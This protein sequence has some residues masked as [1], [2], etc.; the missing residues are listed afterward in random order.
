M[1]AEIITIGDEILIGQ[2]ID[3][4]S[5]WIAEQFNRAGIE[6]YQVTSVHDDYLHITEALKK[7]EEKVDLVIITGGLGPTKDDI[8]KNTLCKYFGTKLVFHEPTFEKIKKRFANRNISM[9]K[10]NR[11]Q[12]LLPESCTI[13]PNNAGTA[14]G[15]W[16]EKGDTIIV[17]VPGIPFEMKYL[18]TNE[19]LPRLRGNGKLKAI[20]HKTVLT[21]GLP[22]SMLAEKLSEW[23]DSLPGYIKLAYLPN[24][25]AVR[26]RLSA[27]GDDGKMLRESVEKKIKELQQLIPENIYGYDDDRLAGVIG[28]LLVKKNASLA[29]AESCTGGYISHLIT[30][31]PGC[32]SY[33]KGSVTAYS[34]EVKENIL[35]VSPNTLEEYGAV[36]KQVATEMALGVKKA[37]DTD[38]AVATTGIAG[39]GGGTEEKP[40]GTVW[41]AVATPAKTVAE[42]YVFGGNRER[43]IIRSAQTALQLLRKLVLKE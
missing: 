27:I 31:T 11:D 22:E 3:T 40:V 37:I 26:L 38:Y 34:N 10:L 7:A 12:A 4:N 20:Y 32:S 2:I 1:K 19:I 21:Q 39:P 24:P 6:V 29:I 13:L 35:E 36:S 17:S 30:S 41:I 14:P 25:M 23:E 9:N 8:T 43:N 15:M 28:K 16:F 5:A 42:K 18:V 33:Y